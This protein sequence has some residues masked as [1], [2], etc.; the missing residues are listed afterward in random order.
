MVE[1]EEYDVEFSYN[2]TVDF[3]KLSDNKLVNH[4]DITNSTREIKFRTHITMKK[5]VS[6]KEFTISLRKIDYSIKFNLTTD[7]EATFLS[8]D[9]DT[10]EVN[11]TLEKF[12]IDA[13]ACSDEYECVVTDDLDPIEPDSFLHFCL[14]S[15]NPAVN[16]QIYK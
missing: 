2:V 12:D 4:N 13:C 11:E 5:D 16:S 6:G 15:A 9:G 7:I 14:C 10:T 1:F 3:Y 8:S